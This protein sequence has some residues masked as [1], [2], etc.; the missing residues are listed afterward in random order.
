MQV[1]AAHPPCSTIS[2]NRSAGGAGQCPPTQPRC[3][4]RATS[5]V[6]SGRHAHVTARPRHG[7]PGALL[8]GA[9]TRVRSSR[10]GVR[11]CLACPLG[12]LNAAGVDAGLPPTETTSP[13]CPFGPAPEAYASRHGCS[14]P[15]RPARVRRGLTPAGPSS[16]IIGRIPAASPRHSVRT[17]LA[18]RQPARPCMTRAGL[19]LVGPVRSTPRK[20]VIRSSSPK[21]GKNDRPAFGRPAVG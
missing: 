6:L 14:L 12:C 3:A 18:R 5:D 10:P 9:C 1:S 8:V 21:E 7:M 16:G 13:R 11:G 17:A 2:R 20:N 15:N 19:P 4:G